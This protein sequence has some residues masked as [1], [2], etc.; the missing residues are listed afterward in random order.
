MSE[1]AKSTPRGGRRRTDVPTVRSAWSAKM[2]MGL[3][4]V[5]LTGVAVSAGVVGQS[6]TGGTGDLGSVVALQAAAGDVDVERDAV[7]SRSDSRKATDP[8]KKA[9]LD[10]GQPEAETGEQKLSTGDPRSIARALLG[11][12]GFSASQFGCLDSLWQKESGWNPYAQNPSSSAYGIPQSL[13]GSK[14]ASAGADWRTNPATQ[15]RWGLGY[16]KARY[17]SPCGAWSHSQ[18]VGWY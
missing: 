9:L 11:E 13:P 6:G 2:G 4:A 14:M 8:A 7:L 18:R 5:V 15:I 1:N 12:F 16:I 3:A 10:P 17:G